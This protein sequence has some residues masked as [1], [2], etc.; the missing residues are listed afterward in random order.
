MAEVRLYE[1]DSPV[2]GTKCDYVVII[3]RHNGKW[4]L[5][6]HARRDTWEF[7]GGRIEPGETPEQAARRELYEETGV[8]SCRLFTVAAYSVTFAGKPESFGMLYY[9]EASAPGPLPPYEMA[10]VALLERIPERLTYPAIYPVL[11]RKVREM[12]ESAGPPELGGTV[13]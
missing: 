4:L 1:A 13:Y 8:V 12:L 3:P 10:E 7:A 5:S 2:I 6:R 9:A 11:L